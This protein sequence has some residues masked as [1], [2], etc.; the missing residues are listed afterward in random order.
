MLE[1]T[2]AC[3]QYALQKILIA[4]KFLH[5]NLKKKYLKFAKEYVAKNKIKIIKK[6]KANS[7]ISRIISL[8]NLLT[9]PISVIIFLRR[10][11]GFK[12]IKLI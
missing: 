2:K 10:V 5:L 1:Q 4:E 11:D 8:K 9:L 3:I 6:I 12:E 7:L